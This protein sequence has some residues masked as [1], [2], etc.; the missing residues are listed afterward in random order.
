MK[1][2]GGNVC[3]AIQFGFE[4]NAALEESWVCFPGADPCWAARELI[5]IDEGLPEAL[6]EA[7]A[8]LGFWATLEFCLDWDWLND[9]GL[10]YVWDW[11]PA[12]EGL[13]WFTVVIIVRLGGTGMNPLPP[14][15]AAFP[16]PITTLVR[17]PWAAAAWVFAAFW[18]E[19]FLETSSSSV[20]SM[21]L[22]TSDGGGGA[23]IDG[24][25]GAGSLV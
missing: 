2:E 9:A 18:C 13:C 17:Y 5:P 20:K 24:A 16:P 21:R 14:W 10:V 15:D 7:N 8:W 22:T 23:Q 11:G 1:R 4:V 25:G 19:L 6:P 12:T 3:F